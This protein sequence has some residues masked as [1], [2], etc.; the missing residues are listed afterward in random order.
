M[1]HLGLFLMGTLALTACASNNTPP[2]ESS[3]SV[4]AATNEPN[5]GPDFAPASSDGVASSPADTRRSANTTAGTTTTGNT[6]T[7]P[8]PN[9]DAPREQREAVD[10]STAN[11]AAA[12]TDRTTAPAPAPAHDADNSRVNTRDRSSAA[13]TPMDQGGSETDRKITQQIRQDLMKDGSLSFTAKNV[14]IITVNGRVT[15]RGPVKSEAERSSIE[16]AARRAAGS[17]AQ[18]DSQLEISK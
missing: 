14:K 16:A 8:A 7:Q 12:P 6:A 2:A 10:R 5:R 11:A 3:Y 13:L 9:L 4:A 15:L 17:G 18:V 1:R